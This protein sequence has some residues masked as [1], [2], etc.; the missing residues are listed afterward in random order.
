MGLIPDA[1]NEGY[2]GFSVIQLQGIR[3]FE[4]WKEQLVHRF[5]PPE[6]AW[7]AILNVQV[8]ELCQGVK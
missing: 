2:K 1:G 5:F 4:L 6:G 7:K 3:P 8:N